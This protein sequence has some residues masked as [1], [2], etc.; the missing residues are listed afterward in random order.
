MATP[1]GQAAIGGVTAFAES[2][3][4]SKTEINED[5]V[6]ADL[7]RGI[8]AVV[9]GASHGGS[10]GPEAARAVV[11]T[12]SQRAAHVERAIGRA[13][14]TG[15]DRTALRDVVGEVFELANDRVR[16]R[17]SVA[18]GTAGATAS[19]TWM[20][21]HAGY[22]ALG[23]VGHTRAYLVRG[24]EGFR[25]TRDHT[26]AQRLVD[27]GQLAASAVAKHPKRKLVYQAVGQMAAPMPDALF[28]PVEQGDRY[29]MLSDG[30]SEVV[31]NQEIF[32]LQ[33]QH[34]E[35]AAAGA[36]LLNLASS[37]GARDD[38]SLVVVDVGGS[39]A[40]AEAAPAPAGETVP[41][42]AQQLD[43]M[44]H[45]ALF[46]RLSDQQIFNLLSLGSALDLQPGDV[47]FEQ[48]AEND[49]L[50][51]VLMGSAEVVCDGRQINM[52][53]PGSLVGELA[54][55]DSGTRSASVIATSTARLLYFRLADVQR[56]CL[57][58]TIFAS[59]L[60]QNLAETLAVR[61]RKRSRLGT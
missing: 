39:G 45:I 24:D 53:G 18:D 2:R 29:L 44:R 54:L 55:A 60:Y 56:L 11:D 52:V 3:C 51:V 13:A 15:G 27:S 58:D 34:G 8:F 9:D 41:G 38:F 26:I 61:L 46:S 1:Q 31:T 42:F 12:V 49:G 10:G 22:M 19:A 35:A 40:A 30:L 4:G 20:L 17:L 7:E 28:L 43:R 16:A 14:H 5:A 50:Y 37:R 32:A 21:I 33:K 48:G 47:L 59:R 25:L 57:D 36:A 23:H 6:F